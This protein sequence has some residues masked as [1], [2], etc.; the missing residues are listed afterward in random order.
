MNALA[1]ARYAADAH[2]QRCSEQQLGS[3]ALPRLAILGVGLVLSAGLVLGVG[4]V[5]RRGTHPQGFGACEE[6]QTTLGLAGRGAHAWPQ[7]YTDDYLRT[8]K[9]RMVTA[10]DRVLSSGSRSILARPGEE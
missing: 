2:Q 3:S 9:R 1:T 5:L 7:Y 10:S 4:L 6:E 8:R